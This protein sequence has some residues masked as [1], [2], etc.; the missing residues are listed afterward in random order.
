ME[1]AAIF[2]EPDELQFQFTAYLNIAIK[3]RRAKYLRQR[4]CQMKTEIPIEDTDN[5]ETS[6]VSETDIAPSLSLEVFFAK[7][8]DRD[9]RIVTMHILAD[10]TLK[11]IA[12]IMGLSESA[13]QKAYQRALGK[14]RCKTEVFPFEF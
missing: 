10:L 4:I 1:H 14:I 12:E 7:L 2:L 13:A 3:R 5:I 9:R 6:C 11:A 8:S